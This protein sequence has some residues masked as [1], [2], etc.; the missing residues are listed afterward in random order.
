MAG[1]L[2]GFQA[3]LEPVMEKAKAESEAAANEGTAKAEAAAEEMGEAIEDAQASA[4]V[5]QGPEISTNM[6]MPELPENLGTEDEIVAQLEEAQA[7]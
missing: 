6:Q 3:A 7:E 4:F 2:E 5:Q 1:V